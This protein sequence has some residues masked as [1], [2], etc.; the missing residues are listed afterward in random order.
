M[1]YITHISGPSGKRHITFTHTFIAFGQYG[2]LFSALDSNTSKFTTLSLPVNSGIYYL[3]TVIYHSNPVPTG[4]IVS[5]DDSGSGADDFKDLWKALNI[6]LPI[7]DTLSRRAYS[8]VE[9]MHVHL[10]SDFHDSYPELV[11]LPAEEL[12]WI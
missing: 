5:S 2:N 9:A 8:I 7:P 11:A 10:D 6:P 12:L 4:I 1:L 3:L